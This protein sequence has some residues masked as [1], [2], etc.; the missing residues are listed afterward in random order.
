MTTEVY[1]QTKPSLTLVQWQGYQRAD[2]ITSEELG[3][4]KRVDRQPRA[5]I[6]NVFLSDGPSYALLFLRLL[7]KLQRV[8]T[9]QCILVLI[10]DAIAGT[11]T[12][13][14]CMDVCLSHPAPRP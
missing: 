1:A 13:R 7:K 2:L 14:T 4:L 5:R 12:D 8:D 6:D 10:T 3:L 11:C 9:Q